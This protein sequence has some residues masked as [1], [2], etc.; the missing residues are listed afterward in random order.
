MDLDDQSLESSPVITPRTAAKNAEI[1]AQLERN[2]MASQKRD[3]NAGISVKK[4]SAATLD[5]NAKLGKNEKPP[6]L[7]AVLAKAKSLN[8]GSRLKD[9]ELNKRFMSTMFMPAIDTE[10]VS[11][12]LTDLDIN[13]FA[14]SVQK[15]EI[16]VRPI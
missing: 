10:A 11:A 14:D 15:Q 13:E 12:S 16:I 1:D 9:L 7:L 8:P 6:A 2:R 4:G 3:R 5:R